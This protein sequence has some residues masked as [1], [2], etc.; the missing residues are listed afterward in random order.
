MPKYYSI[1][2]TA[3]RRAN[4][5]NSFYDYTQGSTTES[6]R[7]MVDEAYALGDKQKTKVDTMYHDK[8]DDL[9]D[10]YARKLAENIN[11]RNAIDARVP[12][13]LVA[14]GGNF[15]VRK[16]EKQN[17][18]RDRNSADYQNVEKILD[19]IRGTGTGG[20][21]SDDS[22]AI[23]KL[24]AKLELLQRNQ[25]HMRKVNAWYRKHGTLDGCPDLDDHEA[26]ELQLD[27]E[28]SWHLEKKPFMTWQ[29]SNNN[30]NIHRVK[31]RIAE[32]T[33]MA[34]TSYD[35]MDFDGGKVV[36]DREA[37]RIMILFDDKPE[38]D[39][40]TELKSNG[41]RWAPSRHAWQRQLTE[42]AVR[43]VK[44][45]SFLVTTA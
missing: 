4:D 30:A 31:Q 25:D 35:D 3:A 13:V 32:L 1:D 29:L 8:I 14:G 40:R 39:I 37:N 24:K 11:E 2:E 45:L 19:K 22:K 18:A 38:E 7:K 27:M 12:S 10:L 34:D 33:R 5:A 17:A 21:R 23:S 28:G 41:Y 43:S 36:F 9:V 44:R 15:P 26:R 16:K 42:N 20:I 6:Y